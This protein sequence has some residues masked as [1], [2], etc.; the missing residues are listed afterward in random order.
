MN[1]RYRFTPNYIEDLHPSEV[2]VFG[3]NTVG[4][5]YGG[6]AA[7]A[8]KRFGAV[9]GVGEGLRGNSYALPTLNRHMEPV[10]VGS[11]RYSFKEFFRVVEANPDLCFLLTKVGCGIAGLKVEDVSTAFWDSAREFY[12]GKWTEY[13]GCLPGNLVLPEEFYDYMPLNFKNNQRFNQLNSDLLF[14]NKQIQRTTES[15]G[16]AGDPEEYEFLQDT[17]RELDSQ[18]NSIQEEI[19]AMIKELFSI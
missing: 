10:S 8:Y 15:I 6:A 18:R 12:D 1:S 14:L 4:N 5:H 7:M 11:L 13:V 17:L 9:W 19:R 3:S 2:F 16:A